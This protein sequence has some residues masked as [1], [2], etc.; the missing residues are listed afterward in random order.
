MTL[1]GQV[2]EIAGPGEFARPAFSPA[3]DA[4]A[5]N[6]FTEPSADFTFDA[7]VVTFG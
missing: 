2:T 4:V 1:D 5:F 3:G 7:V 6:D